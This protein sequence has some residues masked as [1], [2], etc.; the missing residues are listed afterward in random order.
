MK[1]ATKDLADAPRLARGPVKIAG[2]ATRAAKPA[3]GKRGFAAGEILTHWESVVGPELAAFACP[4]EIKF[5]RG[6]TAAAP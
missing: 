2:L 1:P 4:L 5:L 3:L 6:K